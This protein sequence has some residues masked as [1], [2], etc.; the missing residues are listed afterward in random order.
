MMVI[1]MRDTKHKVDTPSVSEEQIRDSMEITKADAVEL[2]AELDKSN[3]PSLESDNAPIEATTEAW[4][5]G[6]RQAQA[7]KNTTLE[8]V[9]KVFSKWLFVDDTDRID[10]ALAVGMNYTTTGAPIWIFLV[11][12]AGDWK[13]ELLMSFTGLP[14]V[15]QLDQITKN[16]LASGLKDT[17]DLGSQLTGKRSLIISP[18]LANLISCASDDKKMIWSQFREWYDGRI[19]KMTGSGTSKKYDNCYVNFLAGATPVMRGE[20][21]IHQA[22]GTRE[23]LYDCDPDPSQNEAKM[24]QAWENE[25][26]EEEMREELRT[27]VYDFCLYHTPENIKVSKAIREFL[28]HEANRLSLLRATGTIDWHSGELKGD[29][30]REVPTRLIKQLKRLW[31]TLKSLD[32]EYPDKTA[33]RIIRKIIDSSGSKNR[34]RIIKAFKGAKTTDKWLNIADI[35]RETKLGRR[36]IKAECEQLWSL[37]SLRSETRVERIG[38]S[39]VSDGCGGETERGGLI[40]E[41]EYYSPIQQE[42]TQEEL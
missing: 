1:T 42:T 27:V 31:L 10:L 11:S 29:V 16:T 3:A 25:D 24:N 21:L 2:N 17:V 36:T 7:K 19:N 26:Y 18:D 28:S 38:A 35:R 13:S 5:R 32:P 12:P 8:D 22:I 37:G 39:V 41:V 30:T 15:I 40:R 23:L 14:N 20:Y 33:K 34:Q 4:D 6:I 9:H